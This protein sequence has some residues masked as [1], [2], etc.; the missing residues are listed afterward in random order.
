MTAA[1]NVRSYA[2]VTA[3]YWAFTLTD[4]AL[5]M[6]VLLHFHRLGYSPVQLAS[7]FLLYEICG[8]FTNLI[9]GW[10]GSRVGLRPTLFIG[11]SLQI[12]ALAMLSSLSSEWAMAVQVSYV[13]VAQGVSGIAKDFTKLSAKSAIK[14]LVAKDAAGTL[15]RWV[16][17]LTGSKNTLKG[18]GFFLGG[19]LLSVL[20]F[21]HALWSMAATLVLVAIAAAVLLPG[22][23]GKS[24]QKVPFKEIFSKTRAVNLLSAARLFLFGARDVWFV[25]GLPVFLSEVLGWSFVQ[26]GGYLAGWVIV[27][28]LVQAMTPRIMPGLGAAHGNDARAAKVWGLVLAVIPLGIYGALEAGLPV[29]GVV[30]GGLGIFG[31]VFAINSAVHSYLILAYTDDDNVAM[32]VG[33]YYMANAAGRLLGTLLSGTVY[34]WAGLGGCLVVAG[35]MVAVSSAFALALPNPRPPASR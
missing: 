33:F 32:N 21:Q 22:S 16:A 18:A 17:L 19:V 12:A 8:L 15:F 5:R 1:T 25:V 35:A 26:I 4:G 6:L 9:G 14:V 30:L 3:A 2:V 13:V 34:Q 31:V 11:L 28:G 7:L 27:Y 20:G 10:I 23:M 24:K 29:D